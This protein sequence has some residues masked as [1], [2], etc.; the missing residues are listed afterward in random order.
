MFVLQL[1]GMNGSNFLFSFME[2]CNTWPQG[3]Y[4]LLSFIHVL[5]VNNNEYYTCGLPLA[6][7]ETS[8]SNSLDELLFSA[9]SVLKGTDDF[10]HEKRKGILQ[11]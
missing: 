6:Y 8:L 5:Y 3:V 4:N 1:L 7:F 9:S 11:K 2:Q 10:N